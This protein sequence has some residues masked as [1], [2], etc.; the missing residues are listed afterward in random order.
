MIR[1]SAVTRRSSSSGSSS[2]ESEPS[3]ADP[4]V[5]HPYT[6]VRELAATVAHLAGQCADLQATNAQLTTSLLDADE[7]VSAS[8]T[9]R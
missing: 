3:D 9:L 2:V 4:S 5:A 6:N 7:N 1:L 8:L